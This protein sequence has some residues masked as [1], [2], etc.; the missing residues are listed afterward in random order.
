MA[1]TYTTFV[2]N[3]IVA[4]VLDNLFGVVTEVNW[5]VMGTDGT[6]N[7]FVDGVS[8]VPSPNPENY[9]PY[10]NLSQGQVLSWIPNP[11]TPDVI[12]Q[13]DADIASQAA[14]SN[15]TMSPPWS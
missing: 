1:N 3:L 15:V 7:A 10:Q 5:R 8:S 13:L 2:T 12:A 6:Y 14:Q 4:P 9:T 11:A